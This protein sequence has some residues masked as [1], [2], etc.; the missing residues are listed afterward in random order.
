MI[1]SLTLLCL[2]LF[3]AACG[4]KPADSIGVAT[5]HP[6]ATAAGINIMQQGCNAFDAAVAVSAT[7]AVVEPYSSGMGG[8]GFWL[9]HEA[10]KDR[11]VMIDGRETAPGRATRTMYQNDLGDVIPELSR[12]GALAAGIPGQTAAL[13]HIATHYGKCDLPTVLKPAIDAASNGFKVTP[14]YQNMVKWRLKVL[15]A[16][17][18][19][20]RTFLQNNA[21]PEQGYLIKQPELANVLRLIA[22]QGNAGFYQGEVAQKMVKGVQDAGGIWSLQDLND[23]KVKEREPIIGN[24]KGYKIISAAPPSS[25]GIAIVSMLHMLEQDDLSDMRATDRTH[26]TVEVMRRAYRD[27]AEFLGDPDFVSVPVNKLTSLDYNKTLRQSINPNSATPSAD[28]K[29]VGP[30]QQG[31]HTTHF[32]II[33]KNGN[34]VSATLSINYPFG[35]GF[36]PEGTGVLLNDEMD[37]FSAKPG[38]PNGYGLVGAEANAIAPNKRMLSSMSPTIVIGKDRTAIIGSP[39]GSRII[40]MVLH[41]VL[42]FT[43]NK[44]AKQIVSQPRYHHQFLPDVIQHEEDTFS[45]QQMVELQQRGHKLKKINYRYGNMQLIIQDKKNN[46]MSAASDPRGEG[47]AY[48]E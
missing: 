30:V 19:A 31:D 1:K 6:I 29:Q 34:K 26:L 40:T 12:D 43:E 41:G 24:Y 13:V 47:A 44:T 20:A 3:L 27:R 21:V 23:Y 17:P 22:T 45:Q 2:L 32:S 39:G 9:L 42:G 5:A 38:T 8:G 35:S 37:D 28:L 36:M 10:S 33:D 46:T 15:Q 4:T 7:L 25:G 14:H 16:S 48:I 18:A 11:F